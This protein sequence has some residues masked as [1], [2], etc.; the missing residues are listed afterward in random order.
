MHSIEMV[1]NILNHKSYG[2][3]YQPFISIKDENRPKD[4]L[5]E[6][7]NNKSFIHV[8]EG[9]VKCSH[10]LG[11]EVVLEGVRSRKDFELANRINIDYAQGSLFR[12]KFIKKMYFG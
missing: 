2:V 9:L 1:K 4:T 12:T 7:N 3:E 8:V 10:E 5:K 6:I 11:K